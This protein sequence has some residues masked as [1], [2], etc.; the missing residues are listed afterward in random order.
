MKFGKYILNLGEGLELSTPTYDIFKPIVLKYLTRLRLGQ[1]DL[2]EH[3]LNHNFQ[4]CVNPLC[5]CSLEPESAAYFS[6]TATILLS[7]LS[8]WIF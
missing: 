2:N 4:D 7:I 8:L 3:K 6:W 5:T 1:S